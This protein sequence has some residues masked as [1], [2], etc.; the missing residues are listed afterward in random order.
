MQ[1]KIKSLTC[2]H[3]DLAVMFSEYILKE[4]IF[5]AKV[6]RSLL[7]NK[8]DEESFASHGW[9]DYGDNRWIDQRFP[10]DISEIFLDNLYDD[11]KYDF[12]AIITKVRTKMK[13]KK[14][15]LPCD[16]RS[17]LEQW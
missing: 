3:Y 2:Q 4:Q 1:K 7:K 11:K 10:D 16:I 8:I 13:I 17:S 6:W 14:Q 15:Q 5:V 12:E 9:D